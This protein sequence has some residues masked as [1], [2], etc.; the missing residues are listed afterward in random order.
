MTKGKTLIYINDELIGCVQRL[1]MELEAEP[2]PNPNIVL[3]YWKKTDDE[4]PLKALSLM[5][6]YTGTN[7]SYVTQ[8]TN[9]LELASREINF[10][11]EE[12]S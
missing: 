10:V 3:D 2:F 12:E 7:G 5:E 8:F 4:E 9:N 6:E 1:N 11:E